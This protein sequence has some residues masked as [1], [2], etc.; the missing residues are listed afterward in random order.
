MTRASVR[1]SLLSSSKGR[2]SI[3]HYDNHVISIKF[4]LAC[5]LLSIRKTA[6]IRQMTGVNQERG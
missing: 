6:N 1:L 4:V 2:I 3:L 5:I